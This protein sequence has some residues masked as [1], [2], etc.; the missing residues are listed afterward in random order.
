MTSS[1]EIAGNLFYM[2]R[3][4]NLFDYEYHIW[5]LFLILEPLV[6]AAPTVEAGK[7]VE[8]VVGN[9]MIIRIASQMCYFFILIYDLEPVLAAAPVLES[10]KPADEEVTG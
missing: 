10:L 5:I 9:Q 7:P 4:T 2:D 8:K 1:E 3:S 6:A